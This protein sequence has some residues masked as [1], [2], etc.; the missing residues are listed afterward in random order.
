MRRKDR[1]RGSLRLVARRGQEYL[2]HKPDREE[3][4]LLEDLRGG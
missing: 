3:R 1:S 4:S 2:G